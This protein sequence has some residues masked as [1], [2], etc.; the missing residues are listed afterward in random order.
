MWNLP[1]P[2]IEPVSIP[3]IGG[4]IP[5]L[6]IIREVLSPISPS[7]TFPEFQQA[8]LNSCHLGKGG[9]AETKED[10][11]KETLVQPWDRVLVP[12]QGIHRTLS[13]SFYAET[14][15]PT[16]WEKLM[17]CRPL[18]SMAFPDGS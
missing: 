18:T 4:W 16:R 12:P 3:C 10:E 13:L 11:S 6:W 8:G 1:G 5:H 7:K 15:T 9:D 2:G 14:E 17:V